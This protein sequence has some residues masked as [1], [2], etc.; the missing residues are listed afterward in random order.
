MNTLV[1]ETIK[2]LLARGAAVRFQVH[3]DSMHPVIRSGDYVTVEPAPA[4]AVRRGDIVLSLT[5]RGLTAHRLI[6]IG[7]SVFV[8][9]GDNAAEP[10]APFPIDQLLGRIGRIERKARVVPLYGRGSVA[11]IRMMRTMRRIGTE[12]ATL[13]RKPRFHGFLARRL[14]F[15]DAQPD[16]NSGRS[17]FEPSPTAERT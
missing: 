16:N 1:H 10:D 8:T 2:D 3:G 6:A 4:D 9:R 12:M 14:P 5:R 11:V 15:H 7:R 13:G 17:M